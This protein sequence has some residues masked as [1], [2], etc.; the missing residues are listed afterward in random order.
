MN[1]LYVRGLRSL[2][3]AALALPLVLIGSTACGKEKPVAAV[4]DAYIVLFAGS[5]AQLERAGKQRP[6]KVGE[7][8]QAPDGI[9]TGDG[10]VDL[11][12]RRGVTLRIRKFTEVRLGSLGTP[13][14]DGL[15]LKNGSILARMDRKSRQEEFQVTS[16]TSIASVRGTTFS[17]TVEDG[18]RPTVKVMDGKVALAPRAEVKR[19]DAKPEYVQGEEQ[20]LEGGTTGALPAK[21]EEDLLRIAEHLSNSVVEEERRKELEAELKKVVS[22]VRI[23]P[24]A[25]ALSPQEDADRETLV[26]VDEEI[27]ADLLDKQKPDALPKLKK[28][29]ERRLDSALTVVEKKV[30]TKSLKS[31]AEI[32]EH[33][34]VLEIVVTKDGASHSGA[35]V[36]QAGD[37]LVIHTTK[38]VRRLKKDRINYIDY[39]Q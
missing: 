16:P 9:R 1:A 32:I 29:Y 31:R 10:S 27:L 30:N 2:F 25:L 15:H 28:E 26:K 5:D 24:K 13:T 11:Q 34:K 17:V 14:Q 20:V 6:L 39:V 19:P 12:S 7:R 36:A 21:A 23:E 18:K 33:Y 3:V 35:V 38:G 22:S 37:T 8:L 4:P